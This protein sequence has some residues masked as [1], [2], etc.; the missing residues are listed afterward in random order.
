M[1]LE[2]SDTEADALIQE[3]A[4]IIEW[5]ERSNGVVSKISISRLPD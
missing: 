5:P 1:H 2:L 4:H 3:L